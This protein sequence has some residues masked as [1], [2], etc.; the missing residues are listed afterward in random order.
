[1]AWWRAAVIA[2][3]AS[4]GGATWRRRNRRALSE[5]VRSIAPRGSKRRS[6]LARTVQ[7]KMRRRVKIRHQTCYSC[8]AVCHSWVRFLLLHQRSAPSRDHK[9][10]F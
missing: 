7:K 9:G 5:T 1:M 6:W 8:M 4:A 2:S 3:I 10:Y